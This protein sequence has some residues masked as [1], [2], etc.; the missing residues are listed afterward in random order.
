M[1]IFDQ[2]GKQYSSLIE[3]FSIDVDSKNIISVVGGGGKTTIIKTLLD[4]FERQVKRAIGMTTTKIRVPNYG[5][6]LTEE[7]FELLDAM[8]GVITIGKYWNAEKMTSPS[9][10]FQTELYKRYDTIC[11]EADGSKGLPSKA[12]NDTEPVLPKETTLLLGIQG[13]DALGFPIEQVCH[14]PEIVCKRLGKKPTDR[15]EPEDMARLFLEEKGI[16][17]GY[18]GKEYIAIIQKVD[19]KEKL[20]QAKKIGTCMMKQGFERIFY[21]SGQWKE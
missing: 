6:I 15:L 13:I 5:K 16:K 20:E 11:I 12:P 9:K 1:T 3:A 19:T 17:K 10:Q 18:E 7:S 21:T 4:E 2:Y 14:R 8:T